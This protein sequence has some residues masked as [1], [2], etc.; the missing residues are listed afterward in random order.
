MLEQVLMV[1]WMKVKEA[2]REPAFEDS[3]ILSDLCRLLEN[4]EL[5]V[6]QGEKSFAGCNRDADIHVPSFGPA[7]V[8]S[9]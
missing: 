5:P 7:L 1:L 6:R 8:T 4:P 2:M 9:L 3:L